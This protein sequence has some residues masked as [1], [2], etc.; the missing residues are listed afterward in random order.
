MCKRNN[1]KVMCTCWSKHANI[2]WELGFKDVNVLSICGFKHAIS[3][4]FIKDSME[5]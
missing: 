5:P 3:N 1:G 2:L 4:T